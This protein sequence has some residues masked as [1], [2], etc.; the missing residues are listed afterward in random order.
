MHMATPQHVAVGIGQALKSFSGKFCCRRAERLRKIRRCTYENHGGDSIGLH[1]GDVKQSFCAHAHAD[2]LGSRDSKMIEQRQE[3]PRTLAECEALGG[4][5]GSA[6]PAQ[7]WHY[8]AIAVRIR[9]KNV[10][11]IVADTHA[12][13]QKQ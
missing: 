10:A 1:G 13:V 9:S 5:R 7:I 3:I 12:S 8:N 2:G 4:I 6:V 11:P